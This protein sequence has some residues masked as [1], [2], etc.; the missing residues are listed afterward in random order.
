MAET[1]ANKPLDDII[2]NLGDR[3]FNPKN[4]TEYVHLALFGDNWKRNENNKTYPDELNVRRDIY[5]INRLMDVNCLNNDAIKRIGYVLTHSQ[6]FG[7]LL[8][9]LQRPELWDTIINSKVYHDVV[10]KLCEDKQFNN[11]EKCNQFLTENKEEIINKI[12][13][14]FRQD[15]FV[16]YK[17]LWG[18]ANYK[19]I[20]QLV[21]DGLDLMLDKQKELLI[22]QQLNPDDSN[23]MKNIERI[24]E[25]NDQWGTKT[26]N[27]NT[28]FH[29][30]ISL[31]NKKGG[32]FIKKNMKTRNIKKQ[33]IKKQTIK[34]QTIKKQTTHKRNTIKRN[35]KKRNMKKQKL[36]K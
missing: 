6:A 21:K 8:D 22:T 12:Y 26:C 4:V 24:T 17:P 15:G 5:I 2:R 28:I 19:L 31:Q 20:R 9:L 3:Y 27:I 25:I 18:H 23:I 13:L 35:T 11:I 30:I 33:T 7:I 16:D 29:K 14:K 10:V 32:H 1:N 34:K 36:P